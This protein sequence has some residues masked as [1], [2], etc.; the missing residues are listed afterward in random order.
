MKFGLTL[1]GKKYKAQYT[2]KTCRLYREQFVR[3]FLVDVQEGQEK[4][5]I[6]TLERLGEQVKKESDDSTEI[7]EDNLNG[8]V[9]YQV[10][11]DTLGTELLEHVMWACLYSADPKIGLYETWIDSIENYPEMLMEAINCFQIVIG[12][13]SIVDAENNN[14]GRSTNSKKK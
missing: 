9:L 10:Y 8:L 11:I 3:D 13:R 2:G 7:T 14:D 4:F 6:K 5:L 12:N 1:D